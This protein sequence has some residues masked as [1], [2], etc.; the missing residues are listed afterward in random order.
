MDLIMRY[1]LKNKIELA[2]YIYYLIK[3]KEVFRFYKTPEWIA[4]KKEVLK[5]QHYECQ[6]CKKKGK[7]AKA[8]TVHHMQFVRKHPE[9]A[10]SKTYIDDNGVEQIN[11]ISICKACHNKKH[12]EKIKSAKPKFT[13][14][15]RW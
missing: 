1:N 6:I 14:I 3:T 10:L 4:L 13:N 15:E 12:P 2:D 7:Y 5:E 8:D 11:L 9:L